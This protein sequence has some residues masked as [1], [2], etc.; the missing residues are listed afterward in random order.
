MHE[1][2]PGLYSLFIEEDA[3]NLLK[4]LLNAVF[5]GEEP[6]PATG[7]LYE[8]PCGCFKVNLVV[9]ELVDNFIKNKSA[10]WYE[11]GA[12]LGRCW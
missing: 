1:R 3:S 7:D 12:S 10:S 2:T 4:Q 9:A 5:I 8:K 11:I 6:I